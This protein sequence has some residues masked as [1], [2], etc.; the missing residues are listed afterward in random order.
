MIFQ[1]VRNTVIVMMAVA[2]TGCLSLREAA[3]SKTN[4]GASGSSGDDIM[5]FDYA[6]RLNQ[7]AGT[8]V[9]GD[10]ERVLFTIVSMHPTRVNLGNTIVPDSTYLLQPVSDSPAWSG[11]RRIKLQVSGPNLENYWLREGKGTVTL[12]FTRQGQLF[13]MVEMADLPDFPDLEIKPE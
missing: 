10:L 7:T 2:V 9:P 13:D 11:N 4:T 6:T 12:R 1:L 5:E 3:T 8:P